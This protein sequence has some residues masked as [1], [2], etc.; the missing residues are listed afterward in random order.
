MTWDRL[1]IGS[2]V[3]TYEGCPVR[4][5][6]DEH[7]DYVTFVFGTS[8]NEFELMLDRVSLAEVVQLGSRA[9]TEP[10]SARRE[11]KTPTAD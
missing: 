8:G 2:W 4:T 6:V 9:L 10:T 1:T 3:S 11:P 7:R 5:V